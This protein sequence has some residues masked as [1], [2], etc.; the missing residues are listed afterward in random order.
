M[1]TI[2]LRLLYN[3]PPKK[4]NVRPEHS[5]GQV[6][7]RRRLGNT[8]NSQPKDWEKQGGKFYY[9]KTLAKKIAVPKGMQN[10]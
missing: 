8:L 9:I 7:P 2:Y 10:W 6:H 3:S 4:M 5:L 1:R